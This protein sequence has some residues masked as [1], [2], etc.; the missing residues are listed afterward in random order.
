MKKPIL[1]II[2]IFSANFIIFAQNDTT[3][4]ENKEK[5]FM[6]AEKMPIFP[7]GEMTLLKI[8]KN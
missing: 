1:L 8:N 3:T 2:L 6:V 4:I 5:T 7:G